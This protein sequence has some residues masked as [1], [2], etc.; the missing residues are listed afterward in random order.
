[1]GECSP[2]PIAPKQWKSDGSVKIYSSVSARS[3]LKKSK[4]KKN[5]GSTAIYEHLYQCTEKN[6]MLHIV[7]C[8]LQSIFFHFSILI[9][10]TSNIKARHKIPE[11][12]NTNL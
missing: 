9:L 1:M 5:I 8:N 3:P 12:M 10:F 4:K 2:W 11:F 7:F 6:G